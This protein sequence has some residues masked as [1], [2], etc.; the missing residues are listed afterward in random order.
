MRHKRERFLTVKKTLIGVGILIIFVAIVSVLKKG[1]DQQSGSTVKATVTVLATDVYIKSAG[2]NSFK[3]ISETAEVMAG[4]EIKTSA[5]GRA[6]IAYPNDTVTTLDSDSYIKISVLEAKGQ[7]SKIELL[8][9]SVWAKVKNVLAA[10]DFYEVN[11]ENTVASVRGTIFGVSHKNGVTNTYGIESKVRVRLRD[12]TTGQPIDSTAV[13]ITSSEKIS[14]DK[15]SAESKLALVKKLFENDDY[16]RPEM[17]KMIEKTMEEKD[18]RDDNVKTFMRKVVERNNSDKE[19]IQ[20]LRDRRLI[21]LNGATPSKTPSPSVTPKTTPTATPTASVT[22]TPSQS[23]IPGAI[24]SPTPTSTPD[25]S[26]ILESVVPKT[27]SI[28]NQF[29]L[30]GRYFTIG[31]DTKQITSVSV[32]GMPAQFTVLDSLT[33]FVTPP[34]NLQPGIYDVGA[35]TNSGSILL[36]KQAIT[37]Q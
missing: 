14:V 37:I 33:I 27:V 5:T 32:G 8:A 20:K 9:G 17:K 7:K 28:G 4:A 10:D 21:I 26:P 34:A 19:F 25:T 16:T 35:T 6:S 3:Q 31:R 30:N 29:T 15:K 22:P 18:L 36:L 24:V 1:D 23:T 2:D 11:T 13:D 12:K